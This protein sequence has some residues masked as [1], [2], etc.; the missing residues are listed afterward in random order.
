MTLPRVLVVDDDVDI[1]ANVSDILCEMGYTADVAHNGFEALELVDRNPYDLAILDFK[2][3]DMDGAALYREIR[4]RQPRLVA[5][6]V[7]AY[8]D[9]DGVDRARAAGTWQVLR[10]PVDVDELLGFMEQALNQPLVLVVDDDRD[11]CRNL[12]DILRENGFRV[13]TAH[14]L[15]EAQRELDTRNYDV[16]LL[17]LQLGQ[18]R[19]DALLA[20]IESVK[21][22]PRTVLVT[23]YGREMQ[24]VIERLLHQGVQ[25]VCYKPINVRELLESLH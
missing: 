5:I 18:Q 8:A 7:T 6:M 9:N 3:P 1:A 17:D 15:S 10:K 20:S 13:S 11:F 16:L 25:G 2:M 24:D 12:W 19:G 22:L 21:P 14:D 23:G 4:L